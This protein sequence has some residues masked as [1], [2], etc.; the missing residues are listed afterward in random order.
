MID[1]VM[2]EIREMTGQEYRNHY[3]GEKPQRPSRSRSS[4]QPASVIGTVRSRVP[5]REVVAVR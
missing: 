1:E 3:T 2:F 5:E 4:P